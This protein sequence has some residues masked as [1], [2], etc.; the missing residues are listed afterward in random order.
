MITVMTEE[1]LTR[2]SSGRSMMKVDQNL[3]PQTLRQWALRLNLPYGQLRVA[4]KNGALTHY[5]FTPT[6]PQYITAEDMQDFLD[7][8]RSDHPE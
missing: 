6:G 8:S 1:S 7:R 4:V 2:G 3:G 5:R